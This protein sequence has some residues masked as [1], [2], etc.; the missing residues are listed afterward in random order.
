MTPL[1]LAV[2]VAPDCGPVTRSL[3]AWLAGDARFTLT[4]L[5]VDEGATG[6]E[7]D[8]ALLQKRRGLAALRVEAVQRWLPRRAPDPSLEELVQST[9]VARLP[10]L[11]G[12]EAQRWLAVHR[13]D[14]LLVLTGRGAERE[15]MD[16]PAMRTLWL[17]VGRRAFDAPPEPAGW[18]ELVDGAD[19]LTLEVRGTALDEGGLP[20]FMRRVIDI[21]PFETLESL[22]IKA[23]SQGSEMCLEALVAL[24]AGPATPVDID[25]SP[26]E[27]ATPPSREQIAALREARQRKLT[28]ARAQQA[29]RD[30]YSSPAVWT[31]LAAVAPML[32]RR[33][34]RLAESGQAPI[35]VVFF[36]RVANDAGS[37]MTVP[38][39]LFAE[40]IALIREHYPIVSLAEAQARLASGH[41]AETA[42]AITFDDGYAA[43]LTTSVPLLRALNVPAT[44]FVSIGQVREQRPFDHDEGLGDG[45]PRVMTLDELRAFDGDGISIGS[46]AWCHDD[47]GQIGGD[48]LQRAIV[49]SRAALESEL[50]HSVPH[51]A[52]PK[53]I[54]HVNM[55]PESW[56][57]ALETYDF[58]CTAYGD[59]NFPSEGLTHIRRVGHAFWPPGILGVIS[60][61]TGVGDVVRRDPWALGRRDEPVC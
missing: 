27:P 37:R 26:H 28:E 3:I 57:M 40:Q 31:K 46:H 15:L 6:G 20:V 58:V 33:R 36:H 11:G 51:F 23:A 14:V 32:A 38:L 45:A 13:P 29:Y 4:G 35:I 50:G 22:G 2:A 41:N 18:C 56:A 1:R 52:F 53:G 16:R 7:L 19:A 5:L 61:F 12:N 10:W 39:E 60:G 9:P 54:K 44:F 34:S 47:C 49:E 48:A 24:S 8:V 25:T 42:V 43:D 55:T 30:Y 59:Y 17:R 21:E